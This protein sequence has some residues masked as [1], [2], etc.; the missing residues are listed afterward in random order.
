MKAQ[1]LI[2]EFKKYK[3]GPY[4]HVPCSVLAPIITVLLK[5]RSCEVM[6]P[7]NEAIAS[8]IAAGSYLVTKKIPMILMQNSGFCNVLNSLTSLNQIYSIPAIYF[9]SWRGQ[10]KIKDAPQHYIIG[11]KLQSLLKILNIPYCILS[12]KNFKKEILEVVSIAR[13]TKKPSVLIL[14]SGLLNKEKSVTIRSLSTMKKEKA[15]DIIMNLSCDK[16]YFI[17]TN[18]FISRETFSNLIQSGRENI[19]PPFYMLGSMGHALPIALGVE[20]YLRRNKKVIVLD[21]DGGCL[22]HLGAMG[23]VKGAK[24]KSLVHIVLDNGTYASTGGQPTISRQVDLCKIAKGC[25]YKNIS[26]FSNE[27]G[28]KGRFLNLLKKSG[29]TF[30]HV[31]ISAASERK[32]PRISDLYSCEQVKNRFMQ[33]IT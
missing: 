11:R 22:M 2:K 26:R 28:L 12:E 23:S 29:P 18:G 8:G 5:D 4:L 16:A 10:P 13:T 14:K 19:N 3:I 31:L 21:G 15:I 20:K 6:N 32:K 9:I 24:H 1:A 33:I 25:G 30:I 27:K 7:A 17:T